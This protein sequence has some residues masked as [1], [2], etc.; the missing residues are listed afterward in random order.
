MTPALLRAAG[1]A[2]YG[3]RWQT[4]LAAELGLSRRTILRWMAGQWPIP[5]GVATDLLRLIVARQGELSAL[6]ERLRRAGAG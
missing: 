3:P 5:D 6:A 2:M 1:Q 4:D